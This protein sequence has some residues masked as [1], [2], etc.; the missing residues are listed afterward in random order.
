MKLLA[1]GSIVLTALVIA[2]G[3]QAAV[4]ADVDGSWYWQTDGYVRVISG[5]GAPAH[6]TIFIDDDGSYFWRV[7]FDPYAR[8]Y[9]Q[10]VDGEGF[11][12]VNTVT[13]PAD[14]CSLS[15]QGSVAIPRAS[16]SASAGTLPTPIGRYLG[17]IGAGL[18]GSGVFRIA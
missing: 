2:P 12:S 13:I 11:L 1:L 15:V 18:S 4:F 5:T 7:A 16:V 10:C 9:L 3:A 8:T 6:A 17:D 14:S